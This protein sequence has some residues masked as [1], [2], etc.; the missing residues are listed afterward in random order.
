M[1]L[2]AV[3]GVTVVS[4]L[5]GAFHKVFEVQTIRLRFLRREDIQGQRYPFALK[6]SI[7][8][9]E[10]VLGFSFLAGKNRSSRFISGK[11]SVMGMFGP[12]SENEQ[13]VSKVT[14]VRKTSVVNISTQIP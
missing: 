9:R 3:D 10:S 8:S 5:R 4:L 6:K 7:C 13:W 1:P 12:R 14:P 11:A 2:P